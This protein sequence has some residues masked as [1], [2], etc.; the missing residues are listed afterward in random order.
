M[1]IQLSPRSRSSLRLCTLVVLSSALLFTAAAAQATPTLKPVAWGCAPFTDY[2]QCS[3]PGSLSGVTAVAAADYYHSL[4]LNGDGTVVAWGC[5]AD[6]NYGQCSVPNGLSGVT[7]IAAG[8]THSLALKGDGTAVAWGCADG[9]DSGQCSVPLGLSGVTAIAA[10]ET[11][12]LALKNDGTVVAWGC[13]PGHDFEQCSV[14]ASLAGVTAI[15]AGATHSL[16]L[17]NDGTVV[18][19][20]CGGGIEFGQ[21]SVPVGL[22]GVTAIAAGEYHSLALKNDGTV[23]A[24]GCGAGNDFGQCSVPAGLSGVTAIAAG[25]A[26]SLALKGDGTVVA[27]GCGDGYDLGQCSVPSGLSGVTAISA[28]LWHSLALAQFVDQ[29]ITFGALANKTYGDPDFAVS[30]SASSGLLVSFKASGNCLGTNALIH[31][32][33]AGACTVTASQPG[34]PNYNPAPDVSRTFAIAKASQSISFR[35]LPSTTYHDSFS[36]AATTSSG[37]R[38]GFTRSGNCRIVG[39]QANSVQLF[40]SGAGTCTITA[41]Q[42]G[43][44]NY[45]PAPDVTQT[46]AIAKAAQSISFGPLANKRYG[47]PAFAVRAT[48]SSGLPVAFAASGKCTVRAATVH[49][50]GAGLC[51]LTASQSG[52][53]NYRAAAKVSRSFSIKRPP[54]RVPRVVGQRLGAAKKAIAGRHCR[55]GKVTYAYSRKSTKGIVISQSRRPGKVLP[56]RSRINLV[57]SRGRY[58]L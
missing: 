8:S 3:V 44:A 31:I 1:G 58:Y 39:L 57:L 15:A 43:D 55:T 30:A 18:A 19:W 54:C 32:T 50:T 20:G 27:W 11:H 13:G 14:P 52:S 37:L 41:S 35:P 5:A 21:C 4:A 6:T 17:K 23:V 42:P 40:A 9:A 29:T 48:A 25:Y 12:S 53:A 22:S 46:V 45:N 51:T 16:A 56:A 7:A 47:A 38:L 26:Q 28:G 36:V 34:G 2:G 33:G 10:G 49:L 24:W